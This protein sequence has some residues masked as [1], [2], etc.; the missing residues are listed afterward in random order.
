MFS[1]NLLVDL[2]FPLIDSNFLHQVLIWNT[3]SFDFVKS[4]EGHSLLITDI[5]FCPNSSVFATSSFDK[6]VKIWDYTKAANSQ[7][8]FTGHTQ[9]VMSLDFHPKS[10]HILCSCDTNNE[11]RFWNLVTLTCSHRLKGATK[12]VR[13]QPPNGKLLAA[14][15]GRNINIIDVESHRLVHCLQGHDENILSICWDPSGQYLA[16]VS[17]NSARLWTI[18]PNMKC[19]KELKASGNMFRSCTF[20]PGYSFLLVIGAYKVLFFSIADARTLEA[21]G[22]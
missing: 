18:E 16:S 22:E 19:V 4:T 13:F 20:H 14:A 11:I 6:T 1:T 10:G 15:G 17:E 21:I 9:E 7:M 8:T 5:G 3:K 12:Q 2:F